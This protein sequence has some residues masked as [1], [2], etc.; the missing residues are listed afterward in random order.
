MSEQPI[1]VRYVAN[2]ARMD[3]TEEEIAR[4]TSQL[5]VIMSHIAKLNSLDVGGVEPTTYPAP[6]YGR[7]RPDEP[8]P[9]LERDD[10]LRNTPDQAKDQLRVPKVVDA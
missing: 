4:Y 5:E 3:L 9:G 10:F 1:D 8:L 2:L 6:V 7:T